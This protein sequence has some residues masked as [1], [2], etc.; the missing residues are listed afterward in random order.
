MR[1][2]FA[3]CCKQARVEFGDRLSSLDFGAGVAA[4]SARVHGSPP[5]EDFLQAEWKQL[6]LNTH[7]CRDDSLS[8]R[9][10]FANLMHAVVFGTWQRCSLQVLGVLGRAYQAIRFEGEKIAL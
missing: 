7:Q 4:C 8:K 9:R 2:M 10:A 3:H 5:L 6:V 1:T